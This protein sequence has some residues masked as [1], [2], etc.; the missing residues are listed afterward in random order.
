MAESLAFQFMASNPTFCDE[1]GAEY[2]YI[3]HPL[4]PGVPMMAK[5][6]CVVEVVSEGATTT[7]SLRSP[8]NR[9]TG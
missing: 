2:I 6:D 1:C 8:A 7:V 3:E 5:C 9:P 4:K